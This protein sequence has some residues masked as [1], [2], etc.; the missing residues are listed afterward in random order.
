[1]K[2]SKIITIVAFVLFYA[3]IIFF[4]APNLNPLYSDGLVFWGIVIASIVIA[5]LAFIFAFDKAKD[6]A[7]SILNFL[8]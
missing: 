7:T 6:F 2:K 5:I 3:A 8:P 4:A 1:M